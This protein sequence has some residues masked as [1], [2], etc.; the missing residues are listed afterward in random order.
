M[1]QLL[2]L[3]KTDFTPTSIDV[4]VLSELLETIGRTIDSGEN[5]AKMDAVFD[6]LRSLLHAKVSDKL[7]YQPRMR[8][9]IMDL[10]ELRRNK[11]EVRVQRADSQA[12]TTLQE[13]AAKQNEK[14]ASSSS[15]KPLLNSAKSGTPTTATPNRKGNGSRFPSTPSASQSDIAPAWRNA[16]GSRSDTPASRNS[17]TTQDKGAFLTD[18]VNSEPAEPT[19]PKADSKP[20]A[21]RVRE[22]MT[23]W[24]NENR[25]EGIADWQE[26]LKSGDFQSQEEL[27]QQ[28]VF[29]V[30]HEACTVTAKNAQ[31]SACFFLVRALELED[32]DLYQGLAKVLVNAIQ[33]GLMEDVPKFN[34]RFVRVLTMMAGRSDDELYCHGAK[35]LYNTLALLDPT[36]AEEDNTEPLIK[37]WKDLRVPAPDATLTIHSLSAIIALRERGQEKFAAQLVQ[38]MVVKGVVAFEILQMWCDTAAPSSLVLEELANLKVIEKAAKAEEPT[39]VANITPQ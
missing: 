1:H 9:K 26:T 34:E 39:Q 35:I 25:D 29:L 20:F 12:P 23:L 19:K 31:Q 17:P 14:A 8:F 11:W 15:G 22:L 16:M 21:D 10:I 3:D 28:I 18:R 6:R 30:I 13:L 38:G 24:L 7:V 4:E 37:I 2:K 27:N 36:E 5:V 32:E 33:I